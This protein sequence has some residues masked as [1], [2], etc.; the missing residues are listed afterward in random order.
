MCKTVKVPQPTDT[1][2]VCQFCMNMSFVF[3]FCFKNVYIK[4]LFGRKACSCLHLCETPQWR[5]HYERGG[6]KGL[7][8]VGNFLSGRRIEPQLFLS[9][10]TAGFLL[11][12]VFGGCSLLLGSAK[13]QELENTFAKEKNKKERDCGQEPSN[14]N[15]MADGV[16]SMNSWAHTRTAP[17]VSF[18]ITL[19]GKM[20]KY[21]FFKEYFSQKE[22]LM[23]LY[24]SLRR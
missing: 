4:K 7:G 17:L 8:W 10:S 11:Y 5:A 9:Q 23:L 14:K 3:S 21:L 13:R 20:Q 6:G 24:C 2:W 18:Y 22:H 19:R 1:V 15:I 16:F 12:T